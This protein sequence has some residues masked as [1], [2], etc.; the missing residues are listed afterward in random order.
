MPE[1]Q[2]G[3]ICKQNIAPST[4]DTALERFEFPMSTIDGELSSAENELAQDQSALLAM[5]KERDTTRHKRAC[6]RFEATG[7]T[8]LVPYSV[9]LQAVLGSYTYLW[10]GLLHEESMQLLF[11]NERISKDRI[12]VDFSDKIPVS[13]LQQKGAVERLVWLWYT[14][15]LRNWWQSVAASLHQGF[16][17]P[18][19]VKIP[20]LDSCKL[21][22][23]VKRHRGYLLAYKMKIWGAKVPYS[24]IVWSHPNLQQ[25][26]EPVR[27]YAQKGHGISETDSQDQDNDVTQLGKKGK[28]VLAEADATIEFINHPKIRKKKRVLA[29]DARKIGLTTDVET[30][31]IVTTNETAI[32]G[33]LRQMMA[34]ESE[35][36]P[37][38]EFDVRQEFQSIVEALHQIWGF[39]IREIT[40]EK[41]N[42]SDW[43]KIAG[44]FRGREFTIIE[45]VNDGNPSASTVIISGLMKYRVSFF[46]NGNASSWNVSGL[47]SYCEQEKKTYALLRHRENRPVRRWSNLLEEKMMGC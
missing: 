31:E 12:E 40:Y 32:G 14:P 17:N 19:E 23:W 24:E 2:L 35:L 33:T 5:I 22:L 6:Y 44:A 43:A 28:P 21:V 45:G 16:G 39:H 20:K 9:I 10:N 18:I 27:H 11:A 4:G 41:E 8:F 34:V 7:N 36:Q 15:E 37:E 30:D 26:S 42:G 38:N 3:S 46:L 13:L 29:T 25:T 1:F 47:E